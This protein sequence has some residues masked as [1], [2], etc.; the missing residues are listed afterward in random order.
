[1][2]I[3][4]SCCCGRNAA[5][6]F[7]PIQQWPLGKCLLPAKCVKD[8]PMTEYSVDEV[9]RIRLVADGLRRIQE[10]ESA[11]Y[12]DAYADLRTQIERAREGVDALKAAKVS[13]AHQVHM[14]MARAVVSGVVVPEAPAAES[15]DLAD[16][17]KLL[18][19]SYPIAAIVRE[20]DVQAPGIRGAFAP[21]TPTAEPVAHGEAVASLRISGASGRTGVPS[22]ALGRLPAMDR[23]PAGKYEL[24]L[25]SAAPPSTPNTTGAIGENGNGN[26]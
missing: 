23:L 16:I 4:A 18:V 12:L 2:F 8:N 19:N 20:M 13:P 11:R 15:P 3:P 22:Y 5:K 17:V 24:S 21:L 6:M 1:M 9:K 25:S 7:R 26:G 14:L 10:F